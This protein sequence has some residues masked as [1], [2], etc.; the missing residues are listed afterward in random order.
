MTPAAGLWHVWRH[1]DADQGEC[2]RGRGK[3]GYALAVALM[4][5]TPGAVAAEDA[6]TPQR[7]VEGAQEFLRQVLPGNRYLSTMMVEVLAKARRDGLRA[8]FDPLPP[9]VDADPIAP[10]RSYL[11]G[12]IATTWLTVRDPATGEVTEAEFA[13]MAGDDHVGSPDGMHFGSIRALRQD[14]SR[15][16]LRFAGEQH[17]AELHLEGS[18]IAS[19]VYAALDFLRRQC[20]PAAAT[21]F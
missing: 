18:E 14:G 12:E 17:D 3:Y 19:R 9:I 10:C 11:I 7:T 21:G 20:D 15:V 16:Y 6:T 4:A 1:V 2:M 13:A 8:Q 5:M